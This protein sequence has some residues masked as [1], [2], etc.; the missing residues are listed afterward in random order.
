MCFFCQ[1]EDGIRDGHVTGVQTCALPISRGDLSSRPSAAADGREER[2]PRASGR[3]VDHDVTVLAVAVG[4][5]IGR[6]SCRE[7]GT[8]TRQKG[9]TKKRN[10][11]E[12][13]RGCEC[14]R[15][16]SSDSQ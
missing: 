3:R 9:F 4:L 1:A 12:K 7:R 8:R 2:S 11:K 10:T 14:K 13:K 5:E 16:G 6:A 15:G